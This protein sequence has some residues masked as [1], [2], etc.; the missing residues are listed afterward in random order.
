MKEN[1]DIY[2]FGDTVCDLHPKSFGHRRCESGYPRYYEVNVDF[3]IMH[4]IVS[5]KGVFEKNGALFPVC[6]GQVF[7]SKPGDIF[8][9]N[10]DEV[11]PF[12][13]IWIRFFGESAK[14]LDGV[15]TV[16]Q[17]SATP[18]FDLINGSPTEE[19]VT[20]Q[21]YLIINALTDKVEK[22]TDYVSVIKAYVRDAET[23]N[24]TVEEIRKHLNL[25]RQY[26]SAL[27]KNKTGVS[28]QEY[29]ISTRIEKA[30]LMLKMG[31][32]VT[33][34]ALHCGYSGVFAFSKAFKKVTGASPSEF[35]NK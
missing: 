24:V 11:D 18:F 35:A 3:Y 5:G 33:E 25:N 2:Y 22:K 16:S 9:F 32:T 12:H 19:H 13:Y 27:F 10:A 6:G 30:K 29:I 7:L 21:L 31:F 34:T 15:P 26:M 1:L 8:R 23:G 20:A 14:K 17:I 28:L 4:Y